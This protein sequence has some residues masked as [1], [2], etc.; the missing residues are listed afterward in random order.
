MQR[1]L[2][3]ADCTA[4]SGG[5]APGV[6]V[7]AAPQ[8]PQPA[9]LPSANGSH[10]ALGAAALASAHVPRGGALPAAIAGPLSPNRLPAL[11]GDAEA[12]GDR[13]G[14]FDAVARA[15]H[16]RLR[17]HHELVARFYALEDELTQ[18][19]GYA[20]S[21]CTG[22]LIFL[23]FITVVPSERLKR[24]A[25]A[26]AFALLASILASLM[27]MIIMFAQHVIGGARAVRAAPLAN[28]PDARALVQLVQRLQQY[29]VHSRLADAQQ[30]L[31]LAVPSTPSE[32]ASLGRTANSG[33]VAN[34]L[35]L[36][37]ARGVDWEVAQ[38]AAMQE[39]LGRQLNPLALRLPWDD[40][41]AKA[42]A[43]AESL[44]AMML[45]A[46]VHH[47]WTLAPAQA[48]VCT[49]HHAAIV[50]L[51][52]ALRARQ[53]RLPRCC[54]WQPSTASPR[55][56]GTCRRIWCE[57]RGTRLPRPGAPTQAAGTVVEASGV[58]A[59]STAREDGERE[60][61]WP[62]V[63]AT[64]WSVLVRMGIGDVAGNDRRRLS[65]SLR[66][67]SAAVCF[68][69]FGTICLV[70]VIVYAFVNV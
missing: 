46:S 56:C 3:R 5:A 45:A 37:P 60:R 14:S 19:A 38:L 25:A 51:K 33:C 61:E 1:L 69:F 32:F 48:M 18:C 42:S 16:R 2:Y 70:M 41:G 4:T 53:R 9:S 26:A 50:V 54:H 43:D 58:G 36:H 22:L 11:T 24:T 52:P 31:S 66:L 49:L 30:R 15:Y 47:G 21:V 67:V 35:E 57:Q 13:A 10:P 62:Q 28:A 20:I 8:P 29:L 55:S 12:S 63:L 17:L 64:A 23:T 59:T 34:E 44:H 39:R 65:W 40:S 27:V 7:R 68:L 6:A